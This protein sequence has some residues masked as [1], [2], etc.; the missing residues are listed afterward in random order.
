[1][2]LQIALDSTQINS[3]KE[4]EIHIRGSLCWLVD[5]QH[6][7]GAW[8]ISVETHSCNVAIKDDSSTDSEVE[9]LELPI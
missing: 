5:V 8:G 1:M 4:C 9:D 6:I 3:S 2:Q 7:P